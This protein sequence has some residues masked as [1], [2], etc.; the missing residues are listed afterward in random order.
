M[1]PWAR[2]TGPRGTMYPM[3][4]GTLQEHHR[5]PGVPR[6]S[7]REVH[8]GL[9]QQR[10]RHLPGESVHVRRCNVLEL[11]GNRY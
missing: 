11:L 9:W 1:Q 5:E 4:A 10:V 6:V 3:H 2:G 7:C 8:G